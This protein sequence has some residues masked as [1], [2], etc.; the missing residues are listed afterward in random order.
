MCVILHSVL[1]VF[2]HI[3]LNPIALEQPKL[4]RVLAVLSAIE[5]MRWNPVYDW[6]D[7]HLQLV[8]NPG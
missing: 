2:S 4:H 1:A 3:R 5:L 7:F 6:E 8:L